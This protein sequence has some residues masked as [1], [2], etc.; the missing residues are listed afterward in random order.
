MEL[1]ETGFPQPTGELEELEADS[2]VLALGQETDL[3]LLDGVPG[4]EVEDGVVTVGPNMMTGYPGSSRAATWFPPSARSPSRIGHGKKAARHIDAWLR[5]A[6]HT[7]PA[8]KHELAAFEHA[9][10]L[11]LRGRAALGRSRSSSSRAGSRRSRRWSAGSTRGRRSTRRG[12]ASRA[13]TASPATTA[14]GS[15]RTTR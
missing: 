10:H 14:T 8:P 9:Q 1:D 13:A 2:L 7:P 15:A 4:L 12:A 6:A 5:G 11:V 3:S